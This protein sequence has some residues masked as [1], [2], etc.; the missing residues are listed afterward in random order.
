MKREVI[1]VQLTP[2]ERQLIL[3]YGYPF[4]RIEQALLACSKS[5]IEVVP[6]DAFEFKQLIGD[7]SISINDM[8]RGRLQEELFDLCDRLEYAERTGDGMLFED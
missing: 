7:L 2:Q 4:D 8:R 1:E 5:Q 3:R 6:L